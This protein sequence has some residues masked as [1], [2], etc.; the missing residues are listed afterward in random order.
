MGRSA[1]AWGQA[2]LPGGGRAEFSAYCDAHEPANALA[3][4]RFGEGGGG[5]WQGAGRQTHPTY[6]RISALELS[7]TRRSAEAW[8]QASLPGGACERQRMGMP[9][10]PI[11]GISG[12]GS[13]SVSGTLPARVSASISWRVLGGDLSFNTLQLG[14][15]AAARRMKIAVQAGFMGAGWVSSLEI[16]W[17][18][19]RSNLRHTCGPLRSDVP[20]A[21]RRAFGSPAGAPCPRE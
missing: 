1:E 19:A 11:G 9:R 14:S 4:G 18:A 3:V 21:P 15:K 6:D 8:G 2:S 16:T 13:R 5:G 12:R 20:W 10:G 7:V 17:G